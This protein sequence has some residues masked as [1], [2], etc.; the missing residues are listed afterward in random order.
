[1]LLFNSYKNHRKP[2]I[3]HGGTYFSFVFLNVPTSALPSVC[4]L[5]WLFGL[6]RTLSLLLKLVS[7]KY[8]A[9]HKIIKHLLIDAWCLYL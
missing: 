4:C 7:R 5:T 9:F 6:S 3:N 8:D 2:S 1:M